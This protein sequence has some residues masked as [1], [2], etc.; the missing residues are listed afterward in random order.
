MMKKLENFLKIILLVIL[1]SS[2]IFAEFE[3]MVYIPKGNF[4]RGSNST[5]PD[6]KPESKIYL[7]EFYIDK[8]E[9]SN[10]EYKKCVEKGVCKKPEN[11]IFYDDEKY[12]NYPVVYVTYQD[13]FT[14]C[15]WKKKRLPTE[16]EWEK[17]C[18]GTDGN[19]FSYGNDFNKI[20]EKCNVEGKGLAEVDKFPECVSPYG[21][22]NL[23]G[24]VWEWVDGWYD[25]YPNNNF[26]M[27]EFGKKYRILRGGSWNNIDWTARCSNRVYWEK[28]K[29]WALAGFRCAK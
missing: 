20:K 4:I 15:K 29:S 1:S 13:A 16:A 26:K 8:Y 25:A 28:N 14:Y 23:C 27:K 3:E 12:A 7:L 21:V 11:T 24:N 5:E 22:Y 6:E 17:S 2:L 18:R 9:V 19:T 10:A